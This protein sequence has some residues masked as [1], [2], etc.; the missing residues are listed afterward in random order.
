M[1]DGGKLVATTYGRPCAIHVDPIEKKPLFHF[2]PGS[3]IFSIATAGC[4]LHCLNCQNHSISQANP[5]DVE[6]YDLPPQK[7]LALAQEQAA[8]SIA[9]TYTEPLTYFEYAY[10]SCVLAREAG[11]HNVLVT[12]GYTNRKPLLQLLKYVD[13]ANVDLKAFNDR[14]YKDNCSGALRP[15]LA[16]LETMVEQGVWLEITN[17]IIPTLNDDLKEVQRMCRWIVDKLGPEVPLHFS[18]FHPQHRLRN[19]PPTPGR[20]LELARDIA[21]GEGLQHVYVGNLRSR[22]GENT[23]CPN[24]DC[25]DAAVPV[26]ER[27][28]Y[29]VREN[30]LANGRCPSCGTAVAGRWGKS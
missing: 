3:T 29:T 14:F 10:D 16:T 26:I 25:P 20:T 22:K 24:S 15:V 18:R 12:A 30:R 2:L 27:T 17:L 19:L 6:S 4:N 28:R 7:L 11:I 13:A 23:Y 8:I 5:E 1:N 21:L 9:Y